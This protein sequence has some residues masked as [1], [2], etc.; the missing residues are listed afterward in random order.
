MPAW[1]RR[2]LFQ[3]SLL[4]L[5][6]PVQYFIS[7]QWSFDSKKAMDHNQRDSYLKNLMNTMQ[8]FKHNY[9]EYEPWRNWLL[10]ILKNIE[11]PW[12]IHRKLYSTYSSLGESPALEVMKYR[13]KDGYFAH[14]PKVRHSRPTG[15]EFRVGQVVTHKVWGY[16]GV[17]IGWDPIANAPESWLNAMHPPDKKHWQEMPNYAVLV[18]VRDRP[19]PQITYVPQENLR[20]VVNTKVKHPKLDEYFLEFD[21]A[22]YLLRPW[23]KALYPAD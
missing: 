11:R 19:E 16:T 1:T 4:F 10:E 12:S 3:L 14:S 9:L 2:E 6:V 7:N 21:G 17:I 22:Q 13:D 8:E 18:D 20:L 23:L 5:C 15:V